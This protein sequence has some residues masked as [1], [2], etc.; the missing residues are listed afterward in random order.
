MQ[1]KKHLF[2]VLCVILIMFNLCDYLPCVSAA[3]GPSITTTLNDNI[4][5]KGSKKTFD[6]WAR[7]ASGD[8]IRATVTLNGEKVLPTWDDNEKASYTLNFSKEGE[9]IVVVSASSDGGRKKQLTY[10][11]NYIKTKPGEAVGKAV[12]SI[13]MFTVGCGYLIYPVEVDIYEGE[14]SAEQLI[15]LLH[16]NGYAGYYGGTTESA[17]Y[18]AYISGGDSGEMYNGYKKSGTPAYPEPLNISPSVPLVLDPFLQST[19]S[20]YEPEDYEKNWKGYLGEFVITNGSGWMYSVNN[21]FPNVGFS[22]T[23][24][25][26]GD[27]VRVQFTLGYGADIGGFGAVG[28]DIP[29]TDVRPSSGYF[30]A[31]NKD[32]LTEAVCRALSS[33]L[34]SRTNVQ[35]AYAKAV[36]VTEALDASQ[37]QADSAAA[38]LNRA[39]EYP[40]EER[41]SAAPHVTPEKSESAEPFQ[42]PL[43]VYTN[44]SG[45]ASDNRTP[46]ASTPKATAS[47]EKVTEITPDITADGNTASSAAGTNEEEKVN[48]SH[49]A[50]PILNTPTASAKETACASENTGSES[51]EEVCTAELQAAEAAVTM[52]GSNK[53][54]KNFSASGG[55][56]YAYIWTA[57]VI[58]CAAAGI[59]LLIYLKKRRAA[60]NNEKTD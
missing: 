30:A 8:K 43:P 39:L 23:Y 7:N 9:N 17:F 48:L 22:D 54:D 59:C 10:H 26:D 11:I 3:A 25:S 35:R 16:D 38:E 4:T 19:M 55:K 2:A 40:D 33:G 57:A 1:I 20:F 37:S 50:D 45:T 60:E 12:W 58:L 56:A 49:A 52:Y 15:R 51:T 21:I 28:T 29:G 44:N 32:G 41:V 36:S 27:I 24:L 5:Q 46:S 47:G 6:V 31:A 13:E 34:M 18:L 53:S 42:S 14:T